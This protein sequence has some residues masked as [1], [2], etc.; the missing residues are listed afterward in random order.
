MSSA[1]LL[2]LL[3]MSS[4]YFLKTIPGSMAQSLGAI[5]TVIDEGF[6]AFHNP[7]SA[8]RTECAFS[9][10]R[11]LYATNMFA[12]SGT[13]KGNV[14]GIYYLNY[15]AIRGY[16]EAG[17]ET[18]EFSPFCLDIILGRKVGPVAFHIKGFTQ[19]IDNYRLSGVSGGLSVY[20]EFK[21]ISLGFKV[22]N[23]GKVID[24]D[25]DIPLI[26]ALGSRVSLPADL[27]LYMEMKGF[28]IESS[29]GFSYQYENIAIYLGSRYIIPQA[30]IG[31][32][33]SSSFDDVHLSAG[34]R[35]A[36]EN[37]IVGYGFVYTTMSSG[38]HFSISFT[39]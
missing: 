31:Q 25:L 30:H 22:D 10:A 6:T 4:G 32:D 26:I 33:I 12:C 28:P 15:G 29:C 7:A 37:Y 3:N 8:H 36:I 19:T 38:H 11:Y 14:L 18:H 27:D 9:L 13:F 1:I 35:I 17:N 16:D 20:Y 21:K 24:K 5:S 34:I 39:P 23:I 2:I